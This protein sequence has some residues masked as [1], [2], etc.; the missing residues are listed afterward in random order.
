M[1]EPAKKLNNPLFTKG[2]YT[3]ES[4]RLYFYDNAKFVLI[5]LVVFAHAISPLKT[6]HPVYMLLWSMCNTLHMP[7]MIFISGFFAKNY[8]HGVNGIKV[9]RPF[10]YIILYLVAQFAVTMFEILVLKNDIALSIFQARS[11]LW[12]L[13]CLI[14]WYV[15]LPLLDKFGPKYVMAGA[16]LFGLI[17]GYDSKVGDLAS[18]SRMFVHLPFFMAGYYCTEKNITKLFC[19]KIRIA[20]IIFI[21]LTAVLCFVF[22]DKIETAVITCNRSYGSIDSVFA[23]PVYTRWIVRAVFYFFAAGLILSFLSLT[24]RCKTIYTKFG[25]R[26]L[27]VYILHRFLYLSYSQYG[28]WKPLE[29][30]FWTRASVALIALALTFI[31]SLKVFEIPFDALQKI[32]IPKFILKPAETKAKQL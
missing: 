15:I 3:S 28:W 5:F 2:E 20:G 6:D 8:I 10:T 19:R 26:T 11:S 31:L 32:K 4:G 21:L 25:S 13:Q 17:I 12:F 7:C 14:G 18:L 9:Q 29:A 23:L 27:Q 24:P 1:G 30:T 22:I 16:F